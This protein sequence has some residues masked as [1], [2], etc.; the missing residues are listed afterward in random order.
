MCI[1][2]ELNIGNVLSLLSF[3]PRDME[4]ENSETVIDWSLCVISQTEENR[5][6]F[7]VPC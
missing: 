2:L 5:S 1:L 7:S 6:R 3:V 4:V